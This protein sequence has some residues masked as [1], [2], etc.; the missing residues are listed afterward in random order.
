MW[1][2]CRC[3]IKEQEFLFYIKHI[4]IRDI[5]AKYLSERLIRAKTKG[6]ISYSGK[7]L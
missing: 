7:R 6:F 5:V 1:V 3:H 4:I 2:I